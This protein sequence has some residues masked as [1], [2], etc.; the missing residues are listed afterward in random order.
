M[1]NSVCII[2]RLVVDP[3]LKTTTGGTQFVKARVA[4][5]RDIAKNGGAVN[6]QGFKDYDSDFIPFSVWGKTAPFAAK[7]IK[8]Q[9]ICLNG[10]WQTSQYTDAQGNKQTGHELNVDSWYA[11]DKKNQENNANNAPNAPPQQQYAPPPNNS[12]G[13][14]QGGGFGNNQGGFGNGFAPGGFNEPTKF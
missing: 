12:F 11:L 3:D 8:G 2:G 6:G 9:L 5:Q 1:L 13:N 4:V 10:S 7:L 14:N